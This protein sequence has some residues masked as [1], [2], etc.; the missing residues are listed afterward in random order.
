MQ[1]VKLPEW[2]TVTSHTI[3]LGLFVYFFVITIVA[4][5]TMRDYLCNDT[6]NGAGLIENLTVIILI[7]GIIAGLYSFLQ[8]RRIMKPWWIPYWILMWSLACIYF[9]G[10]EISW[11][12]WYFQW[13]TP[14][15]FSQLNSQNETNLHNMSSWLN[16]KPRALVELWIFVSG[17][18][19][20]IYRKF[21]QKQKQN[22]IN[23]QY[24]FFPLSSI[25]TTGVFFTII[26]LADWFGSKDIHHLL[27]HSELRE[28][29]VALF[30]SLFLISFTIREKEF[31]P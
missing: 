29:C 2:F 22:T 23:W 18:I 14:E 28:L 5:D 6:S 12:Q 3:P 8:L 27:G 19:L 30:L 1:K 11:G 10:E 26:R 24:W 16:Q 25:L 17:V 4:P 13:D 21:K 31:L 9:M 15:G 7:P 20:P